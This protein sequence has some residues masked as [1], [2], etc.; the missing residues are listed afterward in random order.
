MADTS[1]KDKPV[2]KDDKNDLHI[3]VLHDSIA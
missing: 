3:D 2:N 1:K